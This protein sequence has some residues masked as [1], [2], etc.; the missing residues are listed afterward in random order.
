[1][2][3]LKDKEKF[4]N[5]CQDWFDKLYGTKKDY[6]L[7]KEWIISNRIVKL[8]ELADWRKLFD[9]K[10]IYKKDMNYHLGEYSLEDHMS[11]WE[12]Y[13]GYKILISQPYFYIP[14]DINS[15]YFE[16]NTYKNGILEYNSYK[17]M[18]K[19]IDWCN[20]LDIEVNFYLSDQSWYYKYNS[21]LI[22]MR[23]K[24]NKELI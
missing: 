16:N 7:F 22:E 6:K 21:I 5:K 18:K 15:V 17:K 9:K 10:Y 20:C 23:K 14:N 19:L 2:N 1:M 24:I 11:L 12:D 4:E 8:H 13:K 3:L